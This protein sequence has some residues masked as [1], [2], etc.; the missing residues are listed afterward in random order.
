MVLTPGVLGDLPTG[1]NGRTVVGVIQPPGRLND[2]TILPVPDPEDLLP[3][4]LPVTPPKKEATP[5]PVPAGVIFV[6]GGSYAR[7]RSGYGIPLGGLPAALAAGSGEGSP[8]IGRYLP[9]V[10]G[11]AAVGVGVLVVMWLR[12]K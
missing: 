11:V 3:F 9:V 12:R 1:S 2:V 5:A 10:L 8:G 7:D 6:G 4:K